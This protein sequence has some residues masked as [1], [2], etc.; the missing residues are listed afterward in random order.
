MFYLVFCR[1]SCRSGGENT[2]RIILTLSTPFAGAEH[3]MALDLLQLLLQ[4]LVFVG[5]LCDPLLTPLQHPQPHVE[6]EETLRTK[7]SASAESTQVPAV[8]C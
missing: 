5:Q 8:S 3:Q 2:G 4:L 7:R 1:C 6:I